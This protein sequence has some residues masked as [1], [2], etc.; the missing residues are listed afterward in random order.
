MSTEHPKHSAQHHA[1]KFTSR[2]KT[3]ALV[4]VALAFIM[5]L[6]DNT[7]VNVAI[8]SI[9]SNLGASYSAIQWL[10][11]GYALAFAVLLIT[12]G[13][14]GDVFGYKKLFMGGIV[15]FT[16][17]SLLSGIAWNPEVL[18]GARLFQGAMAALMVPQVMSLMQVMYKPKERAGV[19]GLFGAMAGLA[20]S[21]GPVVGGFLI[22]L[23]IAGLDW[24]PIFLINIPVGIIA[25][26]GAIKYLPDGKSPHPLK[27]DVVGTGLIIAAL[28]LLIFPLI[29]G[30]DLDWPAWV[31]WMMAASI[32]VFIVFGWWQKRKEAIDKSPL[33]LPGLFKIKSFITGLTANVVFEMLMLGFFFTFTLVLQIGL[34]YS[35]LEAA[36]TGIPT[37]IG[38]SVSIGF[39]TQKIVPKLGRYAMTIGTV[40]LGIGLLTTLLTMQHFGIDTQPLQLT[41]GLLITGA[42]MGMI[43]G[44]IFSVTLQNVDP[45]HAG[46]ASGTLSAIQQLGGA[47]GIA[48]IGVLFFGQLSSHAAASF[49]A[50]APDIRASIAKVGLPA[51]AQD[52]I[53]DGARTCYIDRSTQKDPSVVP[54][55]CKVFEGKPAS[56]AMKPVGDAIASAVKKANAENFISGF[57]LAIVYALGL[58]GLSF[59]LS[60]LLPRRI[61]Y[62]MSH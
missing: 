47:V 31:F 32:P 20:A 8:P 15:G 30:R 13:R 57:Q 14:M 11:A 19:M 2:Q 29:E 42:G 37:A 48:A 59:L 33:V 34:G 27:L 35:V 54:K 18:I 60:F 6:L 12:G 7:I 28:S 21:L 50:V 10:S 26:I 17:A 40:V 41:P 25:L 5:D 56:P 23:N 3:I 62:D 22:Q 49:D 51:T 38:I 36:L 58:V 55:S 44:L 24:R 4:V 52:E 45:H 46:S 43:M 16:I 39:L 53:I 9:Q 1:S 61:E